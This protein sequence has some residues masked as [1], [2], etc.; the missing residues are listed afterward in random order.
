MQA[1]SQ[2]A[3]IRNTIF[4]I[5]K[6]L[7][8]QRKRW[9]LI[10]VLWWRWVL[11][12]RGRNKIIKAKKNAAGANAPKLGTMV[13]ASYQVGNNTAWSQ[14]DSSILMLL[15]PQKTNWKEFTTNSSLSKSIIEQPTRRI[16]T[17]AKCKCPGHD[18]RS[19]LWLKDSG[20]S[21]AVVRVFIQ[22]R[23]NYFIWNILSFNLLQLISL[24]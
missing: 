19:A 16:S 15:D 18:S 6:P 22:I 4:Y 20:P 12:M 13:S 23:L 3:K 5:R 17:C 9:H 7:N 14:V 1:N 2:K 10:I 11:Y 24:L 8:V 21:I